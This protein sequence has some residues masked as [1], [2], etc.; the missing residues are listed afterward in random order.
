[1]CVSHAE[2]SVKCATE[3]LSTSLMLEI[4]NNCRVMG[5]P[6][7]TVVWFLIQVYGTSVV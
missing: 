1:M 5:D 3:Y 7:Q 2:D 4:A 6:K